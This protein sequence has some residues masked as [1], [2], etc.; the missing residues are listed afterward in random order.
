MHQAIK[1]CLLSLS[2]QHALFFRNPWDVRH[3]NRP[4]K[5]RLVPLSRRAL[6]NIVNCIRERW[7]F[8]QKGTDCI[9]TLVRFSL[10]LC[11][12]YWYWQ[13]AW[14]WNIGDVSTSNVLVLLYFDFFA[15]SIPYSLLLF[16][17]RL[18][19][20][21]WPGKLKQRTKC[22][23]MFTSLYHLFSEEA[24]VFHTISPRQFVTSALHLAVTLHA[25]RRIAH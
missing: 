18:Q 16:C 21:P 20:S 1:P 5:V 9:P 12:F 17:H 13:K 19:S 22:M 14:L 3:W 4:F 2:F 10:L 15:F 7:I 11:G 8:R 6:L 23:A 24:E 25:V